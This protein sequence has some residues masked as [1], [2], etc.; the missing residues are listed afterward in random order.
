MSVQKTAVW[1][2]HDSEKSQF[3]SIPQ[4]QGSGADFLDLV[5][6]GT[7]DG[8]TG[9]G[10]AVR[11]ADPVIESMLPAPAAVGKVGLNP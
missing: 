5:R 3:S 4:R 10:L 6:T 11:K 1:W 9:R 8:R 2:G 7:V